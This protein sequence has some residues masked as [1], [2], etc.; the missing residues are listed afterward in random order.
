MRRLI[1]GNTGA[2]K[3]SRYGSVRLA[4]GISNRLYLPNGDSDFF[5]VGFDVN[6]I[7]SRLS[8]E[9]REKIS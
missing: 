3:G 6:Q 9:R 8:F 5:G 7:P 4:E 2:V 1:V